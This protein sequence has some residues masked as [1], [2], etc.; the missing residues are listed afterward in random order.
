MHQELQRK[1]A[2]GVFATIGLAIT[3]KLITSL[4]IGQS[5]Y[6]C[7]L[8][9]N[10]AFPSWGD[11]ATL[12]IVRKV[13]GETDTISIELDSITNEGKIYPIDQVSEDQYEFQERRYDQIPVSVQ[14]TSEQRVNVIIGL[15]S[16]LEETLHNRESIEVSIR[17]P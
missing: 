14:W 13:C 8:R 3:I 6:D 1:I 15:D 2:L 5:S 17:R 4:V 9:S 16:N 7:Y 10:S 11:K 12:R